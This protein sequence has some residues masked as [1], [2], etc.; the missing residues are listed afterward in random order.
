MHEYLKIL[1]T[2]WVL[3]FL[4]VLSC[5]PKSTTVILLLVPSNFVEDQLNEFEELLKLDL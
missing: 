5:V 4:P 2:S 3:A 1:F